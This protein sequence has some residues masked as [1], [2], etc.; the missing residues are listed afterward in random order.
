MSDSASFFTRKPVVVSLALLACM[1]WGSAYP[2]I[3]NGYAMFNITADDTASKLLFA[4]YRFFIAG[5]VVLIF[6]AC[7]NSVRAVF[8]ISARNFFR[9]FMLGMVMTAL[10]YTFFYIGLSH[11]TGVKG[12]ILNSTTSF[13]G[14][15]T[16]HFFYANDRLQWYTI[17][18][19]LLG[20]AGVMVINFNP[21]LLDFQFTLTGEGF[22]VIAA[23]LLSTA[24]VYGKWL[25]QQMDSVL[26]TGWQLTFGGAA[27]VIAGWCMGGAVTNFTPAST[28]L[29]I[30]M[31]LM[32][33][34]AFV[35]WTALL[36]YNRVSS[37]SIFTFTIPLFGALLSA[38]FLD[39]RILEWKNLFALLLVCSGVTLVTGFQ[40][41]KGFLKK[42]FL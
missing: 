3:K 8:N 15:L 2:A 4:G 39:E 36:K 41:I 37:V 21:E 31:A 20:F 23:F 14:V 17:A 34:V 12:S 13:F 10:Q 18:G 40:S 27:L 6:S 26:L 42:R 11:T 16:A 9:L 24:G 7:T 32:S 19:C 30:Y 38:M 35:L 5:I 29:L 22:I 28:T 1:L 25:S 33:S